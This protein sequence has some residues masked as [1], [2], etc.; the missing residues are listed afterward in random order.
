MGK[1]FLYKAFKLYMIIPAPVSKLTADKFQIVFA[2]DP[3]G[4]TQTNPNKFFYLFELT[5][6][7]PAATG[8]T[9]QVGKTV[10]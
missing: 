3:H 7:K 1:P 9:A 6:Q 4:R 8:Q 10:I 2:T 5:R